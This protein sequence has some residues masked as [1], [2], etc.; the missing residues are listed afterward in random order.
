MYIYIYIYIEYVYM[1][2]CVYLF[3]LQIGCHGHLTSWCVAP[4]KLPGGPFEVD[5]APSC[6][7]N[8]NII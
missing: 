4:R 5:S 7:Y 2:V 6:T 3:T 8:T 1:Y